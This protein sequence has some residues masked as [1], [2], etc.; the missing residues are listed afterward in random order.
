MTSLLSATSAV[1]SRNGQVCLPIHNSEGGATIPVKFDGQ[2]LTIDQH[3]QQQQPTALDIDGSSIDHGITQAP[4]ERSFSPYE[5]NGGTTLAISGTDYAVV[6]AD[7]RLSSGYSILSRNV[8]KLHPLT[9]QCV[10]GSAGCKTDVD[11]LRSVLDIKMRVYKHNHQKPMATPSVA[12][13][14]G[15]TLYM[16]RFFPYYSFNVL[17]GIDSE[18]KGAVYSYDAIGSFE[19][20]PFSASGSGQS[21]LIPLMD[22]VISHKNR[23]DEKRDL[24]VEEVVEIVKDAFLTAGERDIYTGDAVEI[25]IIKA[26]GITTE[27][28]NLKAD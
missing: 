18:G 19:R 23:L 15:N 24:P 25:M 10:L 12:Q 26:G 16:K 14:L 3:Q 20:T 7:T 5:F 22:N 17:A 13:M 6:A 8:S 4:Y 2:N 28:F 27:T 11:Q 21:F 1:H 9:T